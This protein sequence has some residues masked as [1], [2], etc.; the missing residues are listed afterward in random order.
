MSSVQNVS[1]K[2]WVRQTLDG[3]LTSDC[4]ILEDLVTIDVSKLVTVVDCVKS[5]TIDIGRR[6]FHRFNENEDMEKVFKVPNKPG[7]CSV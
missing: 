7:L 1:G 3:N 6:I 4:D 5:I 2:Q